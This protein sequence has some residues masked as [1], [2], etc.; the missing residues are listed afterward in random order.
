MNHT[1]FVTQAHVVVNCDGCGDRYSETAF[2]QLCFAS[3][4]EAIAYITGRGAG[5]GWVYDGDKVL[6]DGC[7]ASARC[8]EFGHTFP[9]PRRWPLGDKNRSH[10]CT[11]CGINCTEIEE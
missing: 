8:A 4:H 2:D 1:G 6:C 5:V 10:V 11:T 7:V 9:E 3:V